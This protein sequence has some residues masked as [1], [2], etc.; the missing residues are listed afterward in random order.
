M[1]KKFLIKIVILF[2]LLFAFPCFSPLKIKEKRKEASFLSEKNTYFLEFSEGSIFQRMRESKIAPGIHR[3]PSPS[4]WTIIHYIDGDNNLDSYYAPSSS[5][6]DS[7]V[8]VIALDDGALDGDTH[9]YHIFSGSDVEI[10]L[11]NIDSSWTD[12]VSMVIHTPSLTF[13]GIVLIIFP[14]III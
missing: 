10:P 2:L 11:A 14:Q 3:N 12:E 8:E 6:S 4:D 1:Q 9:A 5:G 7:N 13:L